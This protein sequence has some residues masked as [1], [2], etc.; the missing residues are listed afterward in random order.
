MVYKTKKPSTI[1]YIMKCLY[2]Q[3]KRR[4][5]NGSEF[6][7]EHNCGQCKA[8]RITRRQAWKARIILESLN[9]TDTSFVTLTYSEKTVPMGLTSD[10]CPQLE[11]NK[12]DLRKF[13]KRL[14]KNTGRRFRYFACGEYG[15]QGNRPHYHAVIYGH[16]YT[17]EEEIE[18]AW[19]INGESIGHIDCGEFSTARAGYVAKYTL[20]RLGESKQIVSE[21]TPEFAHMSKR[22]GIG[23]QNIS[24]II[25]AIY[26]YSKQTGQ[27]PVSIV[28]NDMQTVSIGSSQLPIH[29]R[30]KFTIEREII[31]L[32]REKYSESE[33]ER[34]L[35]KTELRKFSQ[36]EQNLI[37][38][39][40]EIRRHLETDAKLLAERKLRNSNRAKKL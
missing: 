24:H 17:N 14:R 7:Y 19:S 37:L 26:R 22:P 20:K 27:E 31:K 2:P 18:R 15:D 28:R 35:R 25:E 23:L 38:Q 30:L 40:P 33:F 16:R 32:E 39:G 9:W 29:P 10:G 8:C 11:L 36:G 21:L 6:M 5:I 3:R 12:H 13:F 1:G 34:V 4:T